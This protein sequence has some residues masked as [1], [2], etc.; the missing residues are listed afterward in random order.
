MGSSISISVNKASVDFPKASSTANKQPSDS[1]PCPVPNQAQATA[2]LN[3]GFWV[4]F[5]SGISRHHLNNVVSRLFMNISGIQV[6]MSS[7][8]RP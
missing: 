7:I 3:D 8:A 5:S 6:N 2:K 4:V 1:S